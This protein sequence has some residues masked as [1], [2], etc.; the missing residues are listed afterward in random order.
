MRHDE[1][2]KRRGKSTVSRASSQAVRE[3][4]FAV[5]LAVNV[6]RHH[7]EFVKRPGHA[8]Q[9]CALQNFF[10][11]NVNIGGENCHRRAALAAPVGSG[12]SADSFWPSR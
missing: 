4:S 6:L 2:P 11:A 8:G 12:S 5:Q 7:R 10:S 9:P 3:V 1:S